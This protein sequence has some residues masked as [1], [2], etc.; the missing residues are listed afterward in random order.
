VARPRTPDAKAEAS[1]AK[2]INPGRF[3]GRKTPPRTRPLGEPYAAMTGGQKAAWNELRE[4][5]PWLHSSHRHMVRM[6]AQIIARMDEEEIGMTAMKTLSSI[7]SKLGA[8]P[9]D[10][11]KVN[12]ADGDEESP[13][14][15]FFGRPN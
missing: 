5:C 15:K 6:A 12:H 10:E 11:T 9:T 7:L 2:A 3:E 14:D 8:T 1:G 13:E 4:E